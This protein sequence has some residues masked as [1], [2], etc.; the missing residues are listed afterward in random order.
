[1]KVVKNV[2]IDT[3]RGEVLLD[4]EP[5]PYAISEGGVSIWPDKPLNRVSVDILVTG[6]IVV[7]GPES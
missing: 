2:E 7:Q 3:V 5:F 6:N 1:M 4:G